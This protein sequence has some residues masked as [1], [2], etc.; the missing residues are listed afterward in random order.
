[1]ELD[2]DY[3]RLADQL[4]MGVYLRA[5]TPGV[6]TAFIAGLADAVQTAAAGVAPF[7]PWRCPA[8]HGKCPYR[9]VA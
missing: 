2:H 4:G 3:A 8:T 9:E 7:G 1:V 5:R 6:A